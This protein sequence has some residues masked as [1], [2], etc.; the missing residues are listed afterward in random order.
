MDS[1]VLQ[2]KQLC[3]L[4]AGGA[5][6]GSADGEMGGEAEVPTCSSSAPRESYFHLNLFLEF[7]KICPL[8]HTVVLS[9]STPRFVK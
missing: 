5:A 1:L 3:L 9:A 6:L 8:C 4:E 2:S 7:L